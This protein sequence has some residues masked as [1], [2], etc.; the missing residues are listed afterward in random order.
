LLIIS[1]D[2]KDPDDELAKI[3]LNS[4]IRRGLGDCLGFI[5]NLNPAKER[6]RLARG[7]LD[8]LGM[9]DIPVGV[10]Q[11]MIQSTTGAYEFDAPYLGDI[12]SCRES[13][14][15]LFAE[16]LEGLD[17]GT[18]V[19]LVCLSGLADPWLL[20]KNH[21]DLFRKKIGRVV[22]MGGVEVDGEVVKLDADGFMTPDKAQNNTF[23]MES[24]QQF[25]RHVQQES[26]P[27]TVVTRWAAYAAKLPFS[28]Y[29]AMAKTGHPVGVRLHSSQRKSL[30]HLWKRVQLEQDDTKREGLPGR[31]D[32]AWF[33]KVFLGGK[34]EDR[35]GSSDVWD[36]ASTFQAYDPVTLLAALHGVRARFM[37]PLLVNVEG[38]RGPA[39]HEILGMS[40]LSSGVV[41]G[42]ALGEWLH[43][44]IL[45][46]LTPALQD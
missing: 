17:A 38:S 11:D 18:L 3:L 4:L 19:T 2:G 26:I 34:G 6:A 27:L 30:E 16:I 22:I 7:T 8:Q 32:K 12:G 42:S 24:A 15:E 35:D 25:Y 5:S 13:G 9:K 10:G 28:L 29:D 41:E 45:T 37:R 20:A 1:D 46:G 14:T 23:D 36:L 43:I 44:A 33:A 31:C 39:Q 40:E 21:R